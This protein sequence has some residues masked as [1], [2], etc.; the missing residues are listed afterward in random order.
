MSSNITQHVLNLERYATEEMPAIVRDRVTAIA[1]QGGRGLVET[2][3]VDQGRAK[4]NWQVA[5]G[6]PATNEIERL[7]ATPEGTASASPLLPETASIMDAWKPGQTI[8]F[9][10]GL[11]YIYFL[12]YGVEPHLRVASGRLIQ[13][14]GQRAHHMLERTFSRLERWLVGT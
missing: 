3:P 6:E 4:G 14:R 5:L 8:W 12:N 7:D 9:G 10:N 2:T 1:L 13:H 11:P